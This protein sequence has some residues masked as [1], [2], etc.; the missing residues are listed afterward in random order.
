ML[1]GQYSLIAVRI[2]APNLS[3]GDDGVRLVQNQRG[4]F[5]VRKEPILVRTDNIFL[6]VV[7][8]KCVASILRVACWE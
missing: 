2:K 3:A 4:G 5:Q 7:V 8:V 1:T 6:G